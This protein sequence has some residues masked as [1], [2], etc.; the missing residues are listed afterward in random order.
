MQLA[1]LPAGQVTAGTEVRAI[2]SPCQ[3]H[4]RLHMHPVQVGGDQS[5][6]E[7]RKAQESSGSRARRPKLGPRS[8]LIICNGAG[9]RQ[10]KAVAQE[11]V[12]QCGVLHD[13]PVKQ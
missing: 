6:K 9:D 7:R 5:C 8:R 12:Q 10:Y 13:W 2:V 1:Q 4:E 3:L 11:H